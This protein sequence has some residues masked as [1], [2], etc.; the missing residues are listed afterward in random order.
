ARRDDEEQAETPRRTRPTLTKVPIP[1]SDGEN[2]RLQMVEDSCKS[3][4]ARTSASASQTRL[5]GMF[6]GGFSPDTSTSLLKM[7][8]A[9]SGTS[10]LTGLFRTANAKRAAV[11]PEHTV[12]MT[13]DERIKVSPEVETLRKNKPA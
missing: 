5:G 12:L 11:M 10:F 13:A 2:L 6:R 1:T 3:L 4:P 7:K 9:V 8:A